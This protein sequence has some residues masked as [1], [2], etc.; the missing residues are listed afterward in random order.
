[1]SNA[2]NIS[3]RSMDGQEEELVEEERKM[4]DGN[5][6]PLLPETH[7]LAIASHV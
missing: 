1:M 2:A 6:A 5:E 4:M 3:R 7:V